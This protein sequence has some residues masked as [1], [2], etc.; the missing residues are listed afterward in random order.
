MSSI[1]T[2]ANEL[3]LEFLDAS[4][5]ALRSS[6][7]AEYGDT[8]FQDGIERYLN[9]KSME[10][11]RKMLNSPMAIIDMGKT[12]EELYGVEHLANIV[13]GNW[14]LFKKAFGTQP[15]T[16][17]YFGEIAEVRHNLSHRRGRHIL[18]MRELLRFV[19]NSARLLRAFKSPITG[20][21]ESIATSIEQGDLPWGPPLHA[22][23]PPATEIV[24]DFVGRTKELRQLSI[25]LTK[26]DSR[27]LMIWG[28][29]GSGKSALAYQFARTVRDGAPLDLEAVV[30]LSAKKREF[31][32][33]KTQERLADFHDL[34][35]FCDAFWRVLYDAEPSTNEST[36]EGVV[37]ELK[38]T[39]LLIIIDDLDSILD[40]HDLSRFLLF[41]I[42]GSNSR[43]L[44]TSR[45]RLPG[46]ENIEVRG[47][48][49]DDLSPF[50]RSRASEYGLKVEDCLRRLKGI[51][52]VTNGFPLFVD[53]LLRHAKFTGLVSAIE[54]WSQRSGDAAREYS[55]RRQLSSLGEA[56]QLVLIA[57]AVASRPV[58][59]YELSTIC[60]FTDDDVQHAIQDLLNWRLLN[61]SRYDELGNPTFACNTNTQRLVEKTY[62]NSPKYLT[63]KESFRTLIGP[64]KPARL[65]RAVGIAINSARSA[66]LRGDLDGAKGVIQDAMTGE[67]AENADLWGVLGWVLSRN[68]DDESIERA[69]KAFVRSHNRGSRKED[70]YYHWVSLE[71]RL[72]EEMANSAG[73]RDLLKQWRKASEVAKKGIRRCGDTPTL[74][75]DLAY[76]LSREG[77]TLEKINNFTA[78][79]HCFR[80]STEWAR[81]AL[82]APN[83]SSREVYKGRLYRSLI[84][85]LDGCEEYEKVIETLYEWLILVGRDDLDWKRE[86]ERLSDLPTYQVYFS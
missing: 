3:L 41:D 68:D 49:I 15:R 76:L 25:W 74:C 20:Q 11:I 78:A 37:K 84:I 17:V 54:D 43:I 77:K 80:R 5:D 31:V 44:Y 72:A 16:Q 83:P 46:L 56:G 86:F 52:K 75:G 69:R 58:S 14:K 39:P 36:P 59:S 42:R 66:V 70:T 47:F 13:I 23:L 64:L 40:N 67:L 62:G 24:S 73:E 21:F 2:Y 1:N 51:D 57:T 63:Y 81:R 9:P 18:S 7:V 61:Q 71:R 48:N 6:L 32:E 50:V 29:G 10:R 8:W 12:D 65:R 45:Q 79:Q 33:G 60:G 28:Y 35:S 27:Y 30:W 26:E 85:A 82:A 4:H 55:L 22:V 34:E 53:D 19:D 38:Q